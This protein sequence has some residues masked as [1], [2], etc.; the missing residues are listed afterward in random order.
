[1]HAGFAPKRA[2][3]SVRAFVAQH[4]QPGFAHFGSVATFLCVIRIALCFVN[5]CCSCALLVSIIALYSCSQPALCRL[6]FFWVARLS[7]HAGVALPEAK[8]SL[9]G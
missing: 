7:M 6:G 9:G 8:V 5:A 3:M 1:M 2:H 4:S